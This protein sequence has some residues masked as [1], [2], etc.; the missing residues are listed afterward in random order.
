[1]ASLGSRLAEPPGGIRATVLGAA[2]HSLQASGVT[3][4]VDADLLPAYGLKVVRA[5]AADARGLAD[6]LVATRA[7]FTVD[8]IDLP[9][10][11]ALDLDPDPDYALLR[12]I[13][14]ELVRA[15]RPV[16]PLHVAVDADVAA[17]LGRIISRE[18]GWT[19]PLIVIDGI[20]VGD[21]DYVDIGRPLG[22]VDA[23][24]V[25]VKTLDFLHR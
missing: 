25:T 7:R 11:F 9:C 13:G 24:P 4:H 10:V 15:A 16:A 2:E 12:A 8:G 17:A 22:A 5:R 1:M 23:V 18:L 6:R 21:L 14:E 20:S 3:S 19:D